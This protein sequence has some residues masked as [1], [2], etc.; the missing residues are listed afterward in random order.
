MM[1]TILGSSDGMY[2]L[3]QRRDGSLLLVIVCGKIGFFELRLPLNESEMGEFQE[4]GSD[5]IHEL[6]DDIIR[7]PNHYVVRHKQDID[8]VDT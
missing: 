6:A 4:R 8:G 3:V 2:E 7:D 1:K 5:F